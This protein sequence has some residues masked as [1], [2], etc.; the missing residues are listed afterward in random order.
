MP[1]TLVFTSPDT[2]NGTH[3]LAHTHTHT[4]GSNCFG[5]GGGSRSLSHALRS[6]ST[7]DED[8]SQTRDITS[9]IP[10]NSR[11]GGSDI[12][13]SMDLLLIRS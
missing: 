8:D 7:S 4:G 11:A 13:G 12:I 10:I 2:L 5:G 6:I 9:P 1:A 3:A